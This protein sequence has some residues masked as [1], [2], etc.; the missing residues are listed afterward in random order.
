[1]GACGSGKPPPSKN[2]PSGFSPVPAEKILITVFSA[3]GNTLKEARTL[4]KIT[5]ADL[6]IHS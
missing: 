1:M 3:T 5:H 2:L 4:Q 6:Y